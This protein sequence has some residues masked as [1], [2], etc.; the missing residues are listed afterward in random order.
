MTIKS[1]D[2]S[3]T[4]FYSYITT[5]QAICNDF[6]TVSTIR[7]THI[8]LITLALQTVPIV[9]TLLAPGHQL[10]TRYTFMCGS[11]EICLGRA[12]CAVGVISARNTRVKDS[13]AGLT[14]V[15]V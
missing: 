4:T 7:S 3:A 11:I 1:I 6:A 13:R 9:I 15:N 5:L 14:S 10:K 12:Y 2:F 8:V